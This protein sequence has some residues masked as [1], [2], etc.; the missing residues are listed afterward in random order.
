LDFR[1][2]ASCI[3]LLNRH[4]DGVTSLFQTEPLKTNNMTVATLPALPAFDRTPDMGIPDQT[5][6]RI[7]TLI[8]DDQP[9]EREVMRRM[10]KNEPDIEIIGAATNGREAVDAIKRLKPDLVLLDVQMPELDG[11]G[12]VSEMDP[13]RMPAVIFITA[14]EEFARKAFDVH[15]LDYL[16]K[17]CARDRFQVALQRAREEVQRKKSGQTCPE[18]SGIQTVPNF[19]E[20][21]VVK[22]DGRILFL[23][24]AD[25]GWVEAA[26]NHVKLH[27]GTESHPLRDT[28][29]SL[30]AELPAG[31]F[32]RVS[33]SAI[34]NIEHIKEM[35]PLFLGEYAIL[36]QDGTRLNLT[37]GYLDKLQHLGL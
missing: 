21:M 25:I 2:G 22:S 32:L 18:L 20:R 16:I 37:R 36:L 35:L 10:L 3:A 14:N 33:R 19:P 26:D 5:G 7:R 30:E 28:M 6:R 8:A 9:V 1:I 12:V 34:V 23:R 27:V 31:R 24:L 11:F 17:P 13:S 4:A 15:A 29:A